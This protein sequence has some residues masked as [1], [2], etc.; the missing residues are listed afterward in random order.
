M[1]G[2]RAQPGGRLFIELK[3][4]KMVKVPMKN[5]GGPRVFVASD[6]KDKNAKSE[7]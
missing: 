3:R 5:C 6:A 7:N 2:S 1:A 4:F